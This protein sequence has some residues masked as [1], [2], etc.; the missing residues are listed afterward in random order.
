MGLYRTPSLAAAALS[1]LAV[2]ARADDGVGAL[3]MLP[4]DMFP[5]VIASQVGFTSTLD[6]RFPLLV[7]A[8]LD[9]RGI[10]GK[11]PDTAWLGVDG[12]V[13][14]DALGIAEGTPNAEQ[15]VA[16]QAR[17]TPWRFASQTQPIVAAQDVRIAAVSIRRDRPLD[18]ELSGLVRVLDW[19]GGL[20]MPANH[21]GDL[22]AR[23]VIGVRALGASWRRY[24]A[25]P[26][27][28]GAYLGGLSG[29]IVYGRRLGDVILTGHLGARADWSIGDRGGFSALTDTEVWL[30]GVLDFGLHQSLRLVAGTATAEDNAGGS[31][32]V[33]SLTLAWRATW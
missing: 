24:P 26:D 30:G 20:Y 13:S 10:P 32:Y 8:A 28:Y 4:N 15:P 23:I 11:M 3:R 1:L 27:F 29:E 33:P 2:D 31:T 9:L 22:D 18:M 19:S 21:R 7:H 17:L 14:F 25:G 12:G 5:P 16:F 6:P